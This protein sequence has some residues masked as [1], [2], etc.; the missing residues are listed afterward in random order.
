MAKKLTFDE[1][2]SAFEERGYELL[3]KTY[4]NSRTPLTYKC[5]KHPDK[6]QTIKWGSFNNG[7][8]CWECGVEKRASK[9][10]STIEEARLEFSK[11]GYR[12]L[13]K[14]YINSQTKMKYVCLK[15]PNK[16]REITLAKLKFGQGCYE[17]GE[18]KRLSH[19]ESMRANIEDV[20]REFEKR[21]YRLI[22]DSYKNSDTPMR[23]ICPN[24]PDKETK[25]TY[26][27]LKRGH[28]CQYCG[29]EQTG[30]SISGSGHPNWNNGVSTVNKYLRKQL[31]EWKEQSLK[32]FGYV[33]FVTGRNDRDLE[34]HHTTSFYDIRDEILNE[35]G[36]K[37]KDNVGQ[38]SA[39][40]LEEI[41]VRFIEKHKGVVGIPLKKELHEM[42]HR[43]YGYE[44]IDF[45]HVAEFKNRYL[46]G[47][48]TDKGELVR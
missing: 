27:Q 39:K 4:K 32:D 21:G 29:W 2:K 20:K 36:Q 17:C 47:E 35:L 44:N 10:R 31:K 30:K 28:G 34:I 18:I 45:F 6:V 7:H 3:D 33:C 16:V 12:L 40:E 42:F 9:R 41:R 11:K 38:Y 37:L 48:F 43:I 14:E 22:D 25:I 46:S 23:F 15:H 26:Y 19:V 24:H 1:V 13:E 5:P 8:G